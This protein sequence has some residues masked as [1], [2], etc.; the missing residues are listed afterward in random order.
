[1]N[2]PNDLLSTENR[3]VPARC[4][5][6]LAA[7]SLAASCASAHAAGDSAATR[8][9]VPFMGAYVH[10][11]MVYKK[12]ADPAARREAIS[13][14]MDR[15]K[16]SGLRVVMPYATTTAGTA[17]Y[18]SDVIPVRQAKDWDPLRTFVDEARK[19]G[20]AVWPVVCVVPSG[21]EKQ[22][23][24]ILL[25][26][27]EWA[28]RDKN[29]KPIGYLSPCN[30][31]ARD[32]MVSVVKEIVTKYQTEGVLLDYLRFPSAVTRPDPDS[33]AR[34]EKEYPNS[35]TADAATQKKHLQA[36][37]EKN[38]TELARQI[39]VELRKVKPDVRIGLYTWGPQ[40]TRSHNV[41]QMWPEWAARGYLD[42]V[43]VSGYCYRDN[44]GEK[45]L[46]VFEDR[47]KDAARVMKEAGAPAELTL[48]LGVKTSHGQVQ[49]AAEIADYLRIA[50]RLGIRGIAIFT[51]SYLEPYLEDVM[52][53][54]YLERFAASPP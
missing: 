27:P 4:C 6:V 25:K 23:G 52:K 16:A 46:Q 37:K 8:P 48:T 3:R 1:M 33:A 30:P 19:R 45:Y 18:D 14:A 21:G 42:M 31:Q 28:L 5:V 44:Y 49:N 50:R 36:F 10:M 22:P 15:F 2:S 13:R 54:G 39:S 24:G 47:L 32:H 26:R 43:S 35:R 34:F 29:D 51:W 41:A 7:A 11:E 20:L 17:W 53:A 38:L 40:V 9:A 12:G